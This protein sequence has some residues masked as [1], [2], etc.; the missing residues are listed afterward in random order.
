LTDGETAEMVAGVV[1]VSAAQ[2]RAATWFEQ[3]SCRCKVRFEGRWSARAAAGELVRRQGGTIG[4]YHCRFCGG[5]HV[6]HPMARR[7]R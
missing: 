5:W 2:E 4:P 7:R 6:G 3:R 1:V